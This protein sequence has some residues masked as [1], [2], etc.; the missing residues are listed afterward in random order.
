MTSD[1]IARWRLRA[2]KCAL[3]AADARNRNSPKDAAMFAWTACTWR[4][5][6]NDL[7]A[8]ISRASSCGCATMTPET[9]KEER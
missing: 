4:A 3:K 5:A 7:E 6:A 8:E 9:G 1:L 2:E